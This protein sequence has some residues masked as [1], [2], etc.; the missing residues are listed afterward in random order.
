MILNHDLAK[1]FAREWVSSWNSHDIGKIVSHYAD[2]I[3]LVSP[4]AR[5][6]LGYPEVR[7]ITA[8]KK[9]FEKGLDVYPDLRFELQDVLYGDSSLVLC[10]VNQAGIK[11]GEFMQLD[12]SG[13]VLKMHAHYCG[14]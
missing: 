7:G 9:Y 3:V 11:A 14:D 10:Y 6:I 5:N 2:E 13:K 8:V 4:V 1:Q 12:S